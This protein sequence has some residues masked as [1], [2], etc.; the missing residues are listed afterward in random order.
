MLYQIMLPGK[1]IIGYIPEFNELNDGP[2]NVIEINKPVELVAQ[3]GSATLH[4]RYATDKECLTI[5]NPTNLIMQPVLEGTQL[6]Q[7]YIATTAGI[8]LL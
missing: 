1:T 5:V 2:I 6:H 7:A 8:A 4:R 3:N